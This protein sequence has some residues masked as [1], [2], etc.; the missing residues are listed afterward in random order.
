MAWASMAWDLA[1]TIFSRHF[2]EMWRGESVFS[3]FSLPLNCGY[4][5]IK[6]SSIVVRQPGDQTSLL[7]LTVNLGKA[8]VI[9]LNLNFLVSYPQTFWYKSEEGLTYG[10]K[11]LMETLKH[12]SFL[13]QKTRENTPPVSKS[14]FNFWINTL[15]KKKNPKKPRLTYIPPCNKICCEFLSH[16]NLTPQSLKFLDATAD[17]YCSEFC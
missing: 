2:R 3:K 5:A 1:L 7:L 8:T 16:G 17:Y 11:Q 9:L 15:K 14:Q 6:N 13:N 10:Y 4:K 12:C